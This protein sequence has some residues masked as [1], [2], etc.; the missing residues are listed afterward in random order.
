MRVSVVTGWQRGDPTFAFAIL[1]DGKW[2]TDSY[3]EACRTSGLCTRVP[4]PR[5]SLSVR[6]Q[7]AKQTASRLRL[8]NSDALTPTLSLTYR[9]PTEAEVF[10]P[11]VLKTSHDYFYSLLP[12]SSYMLFL[13]SCWP[14]RN[15]LVY[16]MEFSLASPG[17]NPDYYIQRGRE[18]PFWIAT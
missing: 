12:G 3:L 11:T 16:Y 2:F 14:L 18:T 7:Q 9:E 5:G 10:I 13:S 1:N 8:W 6:C 4:C 17:K 15:W